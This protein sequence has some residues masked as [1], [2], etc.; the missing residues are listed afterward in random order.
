[1]TTLPLWLYRV[2]STAAAAFAP[3]ILRRRAA[4]GKEDAARI[5]ERLGRAS[6][7]RPGGRLVWLHA[8]SVGESL[9]LLPLAEA[10]S[11][12][13]PDLNLL[14]T[15]G[16]VTS[17]SLITERLP[18]GAVHQ[19]AP[20]DTPGAVRRFLDYWRP[21]LGVFV[22]SELWPNLV[23]TAQTRGVRLALLSARITARSARGWSRVP[24]SAQRLLGAFDVVLAQDGESE[25]RLASLGARC[26][27]RLNLKR[28]ARRL[29]FDPEAV[30]A[31]KTAAKGRGTVLAIST[32][33]GED[34]VIAR[35]FQRATEPG[36][37]LLVVAPRHPERGADVVRELTALNLRVAQRSAD[38]A[39]TS[40]IDAYVV[41]TLGELGLYLEAADIAV[42]G[43]G[44]VG[45]V[46]GHNPLEPARHGLPILTGPH[47][48][49]ARGIFDELF[50][51]A[52]AIEASGESDLARHLRGLLD[53]PQI[54]R[55]VGAAARD[56]AT[57]Q[58]DGLDA[59]LK[60]LLPL[61]PA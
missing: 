60:L 21:D 11:Q 57:R 46:G 31:F 43:G 15:T 44:F 33:T 53:N 10:L 42:M 61:V 9:S 26:G 22:E 52:A 28:I 51:E 47:V 54:A 25:A 8:V 36:R 13:R 18:S 41:D 6:A 27:P 3:T 12:A 4:A 30:M 59:A 14:V 23:A 29:P 49:N 50:A 55:R 48:F 20:I 32:H 1:M 5:S 38:E 2:A 16:T 40:E 58:G 19:Y 34:S 39:I 17:A 24:A 45:G 37:A 7:L 56:Y 35:A